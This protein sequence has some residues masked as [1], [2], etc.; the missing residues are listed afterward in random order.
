MSGLDLI[1]Y[2]Y[3]CLRIVIFVYKTIDVRLFLT[4]DAIKILFQ[5][6]VPLTYFKFKRSLLSCC[7]LAVKK[8]KIDKY[9]FINIVNVLL[10]KY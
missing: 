7:S 5:I 8:N 6:E 4:I 2:K 1:Y 9:V 3:S 10:R